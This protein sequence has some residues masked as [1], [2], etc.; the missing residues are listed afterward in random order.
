MSEYPF[1]CRRH[2]QKTPICTELKKAALKALQCSFHT[3]SGTQALMLWCATW[4]PTGRGRVSQEKQPNS[5]SH[6]KKSLK[7]PQPPPKLLFPDVMVKTRSLWHYLYFLSRRLKGEWARTSHPGF[8]HCIQHR[9][10]AYMCSKPTLNG[11]YKGG[12]CSYS[13]KTVGSS[14]VPWLC[15][16]AT[17]AV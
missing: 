5:R 6:D 1:L 11:H 4:C 3:G 17:G 10:A 14:V 15:A 12:W 7:F 13:R 16:I 9:E 2:L 8:V